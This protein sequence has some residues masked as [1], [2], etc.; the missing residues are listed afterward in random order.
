MP[1]SFHTSGHSNEPTS[2]E[3]FYDERDVAFGGQMETVNTESDSDVM[4]GVNPGELTFEEGLSLQL[5]LQ[6]ILFNVSC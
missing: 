1:S 6:E 3:Y 5:Y 2:A 4:S